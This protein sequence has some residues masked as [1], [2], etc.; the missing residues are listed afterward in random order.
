MAVKGPFI[1]LGKAI[2]QAI[3]NITRRFYDI[4]EVSLRDDPFP[5]MIMSVNL[6]PSAH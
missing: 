6:L 4:G 1:G 2:D 5:T 3:D